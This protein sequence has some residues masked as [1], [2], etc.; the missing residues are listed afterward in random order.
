MALVNM[1]M[2]QEQQQPFSLFDQ[3][4]FEID[5]RRADLSTLLTMFKMCYNLIHDYFLSGVVLLNQHIYWNENGICYR[6]LWES[7]VS[8]RRQISIIRM[9]FKLFVINL[10]WYN[11][12]SNERVLH[13][14]YRSTSSFHPHP[15]SPSSSVQSK[16]ASICLATFC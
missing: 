8:F 3:W 2:L 16:M 7:L 6:F 9:E 14:I 10:K 1:R 12:M 5:C 15:P 4:L 11:D 13:F